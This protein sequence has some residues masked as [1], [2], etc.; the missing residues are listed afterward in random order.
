MSKENSNK[1]VEEEPKKMGI[2]DIYSFILK[3]E[4]IELISTDLEISRMKEA[5]SDLEGKINEFKKDEK[6][7]SREEYLKTLLPLY[8]LYLHYLEGIE[9]KRKS[10]REGLSSFIDLFEKLTKESEAKEVLTE[11]MKKLEKNHKEHFEK[12]VT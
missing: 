6:I 5:I 2:E 8:D 7:S 11:L 9:E 4:M 3:I 12:Y 10:M 1:S